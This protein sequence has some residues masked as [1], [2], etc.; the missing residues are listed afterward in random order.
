MAGEGSWCAGEVGVGA[1]EIDG[2]ADELVLEAGLRQAAVAGSAQTSWSWIA[3]VIDQS[4]PVATVVATFVIAVATF[5]IRFGT[6]GLQ[7][8]VKWTF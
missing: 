3:S 7:V 6:P 5:V 4:Q 2:G 8:S 1:D